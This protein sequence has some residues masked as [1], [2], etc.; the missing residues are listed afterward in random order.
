MDLSLLV[1]S[2]NDAPAS[3]S[4]QLARPLCPLASP[5]RPARNAQQTILGEISYVA[6]QPVTRYSTIMRLLSRL[7]CGSLLVLAVASVPL[8]Q[9][10]CDS[11][12]EDCAAVG[13]D[14][15]RN[16]DCCTRLCAAPNDPVCVLTEQ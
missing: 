3:D 10:A 14:C 12:G 15:T 7:L 6:V 16:E 8:T 1:V 11:N 13:E 9:T 2:V 5:F 4:G